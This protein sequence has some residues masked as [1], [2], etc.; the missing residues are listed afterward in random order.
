MS[1]TKVSIEES[2]KQMFQPDEKTVQVTNSKA[3][4]VSKQS[5]VS[6]MDNVSETKMSKDTIDSDLG[7]TRMTR[8]KISTTNKPAGGETVAQ[9]KL[10]A[11]ILADQK[12]P[13]QAKTSKKSTPEAKNPKF[14][15]TP[16]IPKN[17]AEK[18][19]NQ[20]MIS[21]KTQKHPNYGQMCQNQKKVKN[22]QKVRKTVQKRMRRMQM[23]KSMIKIFVICVIRI[24]PSFI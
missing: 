14:P 24:F 1:E 6:E 10:R 23:R 8:T 21:T 19:D 3:K 4:K 12:K 13:I 22:I 5:K 15:T 20:K 18:P 7:Q 2:M 16:P 11:Q 9:A 17:L